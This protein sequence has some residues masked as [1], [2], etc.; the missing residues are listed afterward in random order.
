M[1]PAPSNRL[2]GKVA[3]VAGAGSSAPGWSIGKACAVTL[4]RQGAIVAALDHDAAAAEDAVAAVQAAG[5]SAF[6]LHADVADAASMRAAVADTLAR[7]GRI[8]ILQANA[9]IG[10]VGGPE[11]IDMED[12]HRIQ[13]VNV[14]SLLIAAQL[15]LPHMVR[16][17]GGAIVT[18]SSVAGLRY[19]GYPH[20][21]YSVTKAA[22]I[23][24]TRMLAQQY[25]A[26]GIRANTVVPGL[27]DTPRIRRNVAH[28][29]DAE[30]LQKARAARDR[31]VPMGRMG[32]PWE[33]AQAVAFLASDDAS[34]IT[35]TELVVDGGIIGKYV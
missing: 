24:F 11:D 25:A 4:A 3:L 14:D 16:Q 1:M 35:G 33:V 2:A 26:Q 7:H 13:R 18:V 23:H 10:K 6:P 31:Q 9:G 12:W 32:T 19:I 28:M 15:V 5:G 17:G 30:D 8:D 27:I 21:A 22:A 34:Y 20:L 29:F